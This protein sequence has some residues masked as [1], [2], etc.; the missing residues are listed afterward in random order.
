M[1]KT[2]KT[3]FLVA[4]L[5]FIFACSLLVPAS[6]APTP[7]VSRKP[8]VLT[9]STPEVLIPTEAGDPIEYI[10]PERYRVDSVARVTNGGFTLTELQVYQP[11]PVNWDGQ[12]KVKIEE[13]F[14]ASAQVGRDEVTGSEM[15]YWHLKNT[16]GWGKTQDLR[17]RFTFT[18]YETRTAIDPESVKPYNTLTAE[19]RL[20]TRAEPYLEANDPKIIALADRIGGNETN[21]YLLARKFYDHV[22]DAARYQGVDGLQG[23]KALL[24]TGVGEC[25]DYSALFIALAR[26][27]KIPARSVVG[28]W[29]ISGT[30]QTHVWAEFYL[31]GIGWVPADPTVGQSER[32]REG[33]QDYY[34]GNMDNQRVILSKGFNIKLDPP[35]PDA[36]VASL[37]QMPW[38]WFWGTGGDAS[39]VSLR[40]TEWSVMPG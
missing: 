3:F 33:I 30:N 39:A 29:A 12:E 24:E 27:K 22:V 15:Y 1:K 21:P 11:K 13:V 8:F 31:E 38:W 32:Y 23:A 19:Y 6:P 37:L 5:F 16:P 20:F 9:T 14:P 18:A 7:T 36:T 40:M 35:A 4:G 28:F 26:V 34:F 2:L 25:G 17:Y 10:N